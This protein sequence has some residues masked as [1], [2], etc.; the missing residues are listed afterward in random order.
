MN[1]LGGM[2]AVGL[3]G[4]QSG[5]G[6]TQVINFVGIGLTVGGGSSVDTTTQWNLGIG[7]G[8]EF[9]VKRLGDD[10]IANSPPPNGETQVRFQTT[11]VS[12]PFLFFTAHW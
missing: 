1:C 9:G 6:G 8:R 4:N 2:I 11:D 5:T 10:F 7:Y 3:G 12:A